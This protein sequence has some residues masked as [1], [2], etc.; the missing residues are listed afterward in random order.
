MFYPRGVSNWMVVRD[1]D[2]SAQFD[3]FGRER[4]PSLSRAASAVANGTSRNGA[5]DWQPVNDTSAL[6]AEVAAWAAGHPD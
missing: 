5:K 3:V 1:G 2:A 6:P 4:Y